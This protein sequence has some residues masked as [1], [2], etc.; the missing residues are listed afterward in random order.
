M[1]TQ[2]SR[3]G[4]LRAG[5]GAAA[6]AG[7]GV[8]GLATGSP[9]FA[10][11]PDSQLPEVPGMLGD[12][13]AN[14][15]WYQ[16]DQTTLFARSQE[17]TDAF[18]AIQR[19]VAGAGQ[20]TTFIQAWLDMAAS[21]DYPA[22]FTAYVEPLRQ[23][24]QTL[25]TVEATIFD[26]YYRR[27]DPRLVGAFGDFAQGVLYDPRRLDVGAPVHTMNGDPP[28]GYP[29]WHVFMRSMMFL[30]IDRQRWRELA[31]LNAFAWQVQTLAKPD[32]QAVNPPLPRRTV[33]E[34]AETW[35]PRGMAEL[36]VAF[37]GFPFPAAG[38]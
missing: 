8:G 13:R 24:M 10:D 4:L 2:M 27:R 23:P 29:F 31:P 17:V 32:E 26:T 7:L 16:F 19:Y 20:E 34:L 15:F 6:V 9:A 37:R 25:S 1:S 38:G 5:L 22:N 21:S 3:R 30:D 14:E 35:L 11:C 18:I 12:R 36:D 28:I 33:R